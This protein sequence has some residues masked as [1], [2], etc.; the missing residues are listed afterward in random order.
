[1]NQH[2]WKETAGG[3]AIPRKIAV[4]YQWGDGPVCVSESAKDPNETADLLIEYVALASEAIFVKKRS[5]PSWL[6]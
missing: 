6:L 3:P 1:M 2:F 5:V 4:K